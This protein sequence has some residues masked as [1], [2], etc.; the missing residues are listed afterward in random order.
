MSLVTNCIAEGTTQD[1]AAMGRLVGI[2]YFSSQNAYDDQQLDAADL[3]RAKQERDGDELDDE[4]DPY[5]L[6]QVNISLRMQKQ[7]DGRVIRRTVTSR[8][9]AGKCLIDLPPLTIIY[10][11]IDLTEREM[12][13]IN[14][15]T[16]A[17][18][19]VYAFI[20][21]A[22]CLVLTIF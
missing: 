22:I 18:L 13:I 17:N 3:R 11:V 15:Q 6:C 9:P 5:K 1:L 10:G 4:N 19:D 2:P 16:E 12:A 20:I 14:M 7:F 21:Y 8:D